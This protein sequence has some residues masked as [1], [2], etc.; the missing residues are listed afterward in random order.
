MLDQNNHVTRLID[1]FQTYEEDQISLFIVMEFMD[2]NL[3]SFMTGKSNLKFESLTEEQS[4]LIFYKS[5]CGLKFLHSANILHRDIKPSNILI[6]KDLNVKICDFGLARTLPK[7]CV[8]RGSG[9]SNRIR[10]AIINA[11]LYDHSNLPQLK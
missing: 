7:S 1:V 3:K 9:N 8:G 11:N 5:I 4:F 10:N 2:S 6:D